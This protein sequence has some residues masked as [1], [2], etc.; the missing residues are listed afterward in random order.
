MKQL[1]YVTFILCSLDVFSQDIEKTIFFKVLRKDCTLIL[2][3]KNRNKK[4][5]QIPD[6]SLRTYE[7]NGMKTLKD[8]FIEVNDQVLTIRVN[9][10]CNNKDEDRLNVTDVSSNSKITIRY[11]DLNIKGKKTQFVRLPKKFCSM[12]IKSVQVVYND[13]VLGVSSVVL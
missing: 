12:K 10:I 5:L 7:A 4:S 11:N 6:F 3:F 13:Q 2:T 9:E 1:V 8:E